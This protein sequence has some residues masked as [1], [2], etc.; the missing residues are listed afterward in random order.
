[1]LWHS[2]RCT[3][4]PNRKDVYWG[5]IWAVYIIK[6]ADAKRLECLG[7]GEQPYDASGRLSSSS[8]ISSAGAPSEGASS[9]GAS[10]GGAS[11][12]G[13]SS[14]RASSVHA[15]PW[16]ASEGNSGGVSSTILAQLDIVSLIAF[17]VG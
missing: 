16:D 14:K 4:W 1:M 12:G 6:L 17:S 11:S 15:S 5:R 10:S 3:I 7:N 2:V 8:G 9:G 13:A